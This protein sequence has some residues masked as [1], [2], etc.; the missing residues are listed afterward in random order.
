VPERLGTAHT[1]PNG[2]AILTISGNRTV[3]SQKLLEYLQRQT[4]ILAHAEDVNGIML[5]GSE[6]GFCH[7]SAE[8]S[9]SPHSA[10]Q[11]SSFGQKTLFNLEK[12]G[13]PCIAVIEGE[14]SGLGLEIA[15]ACDFIVASQSASFGFPGIA[16]GLIPFCGGS[17]RLA[18]LVG[19]SKTKELIYSGDLIS[20]DEAYRIALVNRLYPSGEA[21][22]QAEKLLEHICTRSASAIRIGGEV[23]NAGYD[24]D[25][26]TACMLERDAFALCFS[27]FDQ[28]EGMQAFLDKRAPHFK[29]E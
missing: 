4:A 18:R 8:R 16:A 1:T 29:G 27:S 5:T 12:T 17:Q 2:V 19:K 15:L 10:S 21:L 3:T 25:L 13:K 26:Q 24:I 28:R 9:A 20:A 6:S 22:L 14:C 23:V 11:L 7:C